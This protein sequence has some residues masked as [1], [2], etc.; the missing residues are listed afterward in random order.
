MT[1][2]YSSDSP[3]RKNKD[4]KFN[5]WQFS[6]RVAD[7]IANRIDPS[8]IVIG[9]YGAWGNGKTSVL[10]FIEEALTDKEEVIC[11]KFNPWRFGT[12]DDLLKAFF[13]EIAQALDTKLITNTD[14]VKDVV[15]SLAPAVT[16]IFGTSEVGQV[17]SGFIP[18][19]ELEKLKQRIESALEKTKKRVLIIIDDVDR[20]EKSE[21]H[22]LFKLVKL[23]ADFKYTAY[24]LAFDKDIVASSLQDRY[25]SSTS[26]AGEAFLEKIIQVPLNLP[27][28]DQPTLIEFCFQGVDEALNVADIE[29]SQD[30]ASEYA[31]K[32]TRYFGS[33][34]T[35]PRKAKLYGNILLFSLPILKGEVNVIELMLIEAIKVFYPPV[36]NLL[37]TNKELFSG[38]FSESRYTS[39]EAD[40]NTIKKLIDQAINLCD[41]VDS[42]KIIH[43]LKDLFPKIQSSYQNMYYGSEWYTIWDNQQRVCAQNYYS[44]YFTYSIANEDISDI[45]IKEILTK[46][47]LWQE[48]F[49]FNE[50]PLNGILNDINAEKL[51]SKLR[52]KA[53]N[54]SEEVSFSLC[55]AI[56]QKSDQ[57]P[58]VLKLFDWFTPVIQGAILL[59]DL[60]QNTVKEKRLAQIKLI[61]NHIDNLDFLFDVLH[62]LKIYDDQRPEE[63]DVLSISEMA[64]L[65]KYA[66]SHVEAKLS[67]GI[68]IIKTTP[69]NLPSLLRMLNKCFHSNF[70]NELLKKRLSNEPKILIKIIT[71]YLG[72]AEGGNRSRPHRSDLKFEQYQQIIKQIDIE[73]LIGF[74][75]QNFELEILFSKDFPE[76]YDHLEDGDFIFIK[77][78]YWFY[79][80]RDEDG[81]NENSQLLD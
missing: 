3:V 74:I 18:S 4:D 44:R 40:K 45:T 57:L 16:S 31:S 28:I 71:S 64:E 78:L 55:I 56:G 41:N 13:F 54:L 29:I 49:N 46:C 33:A 68:D 38:T 35:T 51:I 65:S 21:I 75:E 2:S 23:T 81:L 34:V 39:N 27:L 5:R 60:V 36:Y 30:Q 53:N 6:K 79:K 42:E 10:N 8:S 24:I 66:T 73:M 37:R 62:W 26:N 50:N 20:L 11:I 22:A 48:N 25:S 80:N 63:T 69:R 58:Y 7:V 19:I 32:F 72:I 1:D 9:L 67:S 14:K 77:Q 61:I 47:V 43:L 15:K 52:T 17:I 76:Q 70:V 12:E 59:S